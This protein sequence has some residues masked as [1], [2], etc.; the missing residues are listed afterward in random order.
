MD[1]VTPH[2][3]SVIMQMVRASNTKPELA[4]RKLLHG[5]G[6][7]FRLQKKNLPGTPDI[8]L[9]RWRAVVLIHG[10]FWH[11]HDGC[12]KA[13]TPKSN[14]KYWCQKFHANVERDRRVATRLKS[15]GWRVCVVWQCELSD[16]QRLESR[17]ARFIRKGAKH[18]V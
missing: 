12:R 13:T 10:C 1:H 2:R 11:R 15:M 6:F 4:V 17:L 18:R 8:V 5:L 9:P 14:T 7:R 16:P 3:R